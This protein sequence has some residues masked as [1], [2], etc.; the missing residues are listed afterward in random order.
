MPSD[1]GEDVSTGWK[2]PSLCRLFLNLLH[3]RKRLHS[4]QEAIPARRS[5]MHPA[6]FLTYLV[7][8]LRCIIRLLRG[9]YPMTCPRLIDQTETM[10]TS[11]LVHEKLLFPI[12]QRTESTLAAS[13]VRDLA[14]AVSDSIP[15]A[16]AH[17]SFVRYV[18]LSS[19]S[20]GFV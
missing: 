1:R 9:S 12:T 6:I 18:A 15:V 10:L 17:L 8:R 2:I 11:F 16:H 4:V 19:E 20:S 13:C 14:V 3:D 7:G 5:I